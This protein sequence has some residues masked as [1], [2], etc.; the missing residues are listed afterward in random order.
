MLSELTDDRWT[1]HQPFYIENREVAT[2]GYSQSL[3]NEE[4]VEITFIV[5]FIFDDDFVVFQ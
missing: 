5:L 3:S 1:T 2:V 4:S